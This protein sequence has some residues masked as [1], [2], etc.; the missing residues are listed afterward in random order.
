MPQEH[1]TGSGLSLCSQ[2]IGMGVVGTH[3]FILPLIPNV[4]PVNINAIV[5]EDRIATHVRQRVSTPVVTRLRWPPLMP[6]TMWL[7]TWVSWHTCKPHNPAYFYHYKTD[8]TLC[9]WH[10]CMRTLQEASCDRYP[11]EQANPRWSG[12]PP[13][14]QLRSFG[15][16][17]FDD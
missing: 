13:L 11:A 4:V 10:S 5:H 6:R 8:A 14:Q 15:M 9:T 1:K 3:F 2:C 16:P 17:V 7:P 12:A